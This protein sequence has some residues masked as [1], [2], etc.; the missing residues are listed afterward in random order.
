MKLPRSNDITFTFLVLY[1][2]PETSLLHPQEQGNKYLH[3]SLS[4]LFLFLF[5]T[6]FFLSPFPL[7]SFLK[8]QPSHF[9]IMAI[10]FVVEYTYSFV[11]NCQNIA[12]YNATRNK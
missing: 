9:P 8:W 1:Q 6:L 10:C 7:Y 5:I 3:L 2:S 4:S 12:E 11:Q